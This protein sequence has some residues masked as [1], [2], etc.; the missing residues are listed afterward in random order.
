MR[1][2]DLPRLVELL[3]QLSLD[4]PREDLS[5]PLSPAYYAAME[6]ILADERQTMLVVA[7]DGIVA[8]M[9]CFV[10]VPN[11]SHVGRPWAV[12]EDVVVD[13]AMRGQGCGELLMNAALDLARRH[14]CYKLS[15]TSNNARQDAHRFYKSLGFKATHTG[16]RVDLD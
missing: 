5:Q 6:A 12:V 10:L 9:A 8:G 13:A 11:L 7:V 4:S 15:L 16:F 1:R 2:S 3:A 14:G